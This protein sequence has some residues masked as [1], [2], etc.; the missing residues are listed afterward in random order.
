MDYEKE[1]KRIRRYRLVILLA[2]ILTPLV[3]LTAPT[4]VSVFAWI[5]FTVGN[6]LNVGAIIVTA[7]TYTFLLYGLGVRF[8]IINGLLK[9]EICGI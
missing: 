7:I 9:W 5:H 1:Q 6:S 8:S 3:I 4:R 2:M